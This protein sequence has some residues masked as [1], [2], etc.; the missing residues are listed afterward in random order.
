MPNFKL[1]YVN[2]CTY[3]TNVA[4]LY[5]FGASF[6][7]FEAS[8]INHIGFKSLWRVKFWQIAMPDLV[9]IYLHY[10]LDT[11]I[12]IVPRYNRVNI[13]SDK[14][15]WMTSYFSVTCN[16]L[17]Y[18]LVFS[19]TSKITLKQCWT[20]FYDTNAQT[21]Y[22]RHTEIDPILSVSGLWPVLPPVTLVAMN[23]QV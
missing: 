9:S 21:N 3:S 20:L 7:C 12:W 13:L 4:K 22:L 6:S 19:C 11:A 1:Q 10:L 16:V 15:Y 14:V 2:Y 8:Y 5:I 23:S 17:I 18:N